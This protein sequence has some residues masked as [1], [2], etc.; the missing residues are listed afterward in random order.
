M[1]SDECS[2]ETAALRAADSAIAHAS[3]QNSGGFMAKLA[4]RGHAS[5]HCVPG[6]SG[7]VRCTKATTA[8]RAPNMVDLYHK[9][10]AAAVRVSQSCA[11]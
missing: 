7:H 1:F 3:R 4:S 9:R 6:R 2:R 11:G 10:D 8:A 5:Y